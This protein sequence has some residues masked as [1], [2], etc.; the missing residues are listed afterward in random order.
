MRTP[1]TYINTDARLYGLE[2]D[3]THH[4]TP[5]WTLSATAALTRG[6]DRRQHAPLPQL[7]PFETDVSLKYRHSAW[8]AGLLWRIVA[9]Q[10]RC[11][12]GYGSET[13]VDTAPTGG[14]GI[15]SLNAAYKATD[16]MTFSCGIDNIFNKKYAE[17]VSYKEATI[18]NLGIIGHEHINEPG[19]TVWFKANYRF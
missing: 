14:F 5:H 12:P 4:F 3:Y 11:R 8:E 18:S 16:A 19:R 6:S 9:S 10:K 17:F 2:A 15:V 13:G 7:A 1:Q